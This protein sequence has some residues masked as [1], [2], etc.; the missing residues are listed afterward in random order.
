MF[1]LDASAIIALAKR[2]RETLPYVLK[3]KRTLSLAFYEVG[4]FVWKEAVLIKKLGVRKAVEIAKDFTNALLLMDIIYPDIRTDMCEVCAIAARTGLT[5][6]DAAYLYVAIRDG[7]ALVT[8]DREL[9]EKAR[10]L[11]VRVLSAEELLSGL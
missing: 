3:G 4:N 10:E 7:L 8:E 5:F 11:G 6:Y 1:L 9:A 2:A